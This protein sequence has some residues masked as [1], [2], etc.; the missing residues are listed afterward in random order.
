M[1]KKT[2]YRHI[3]GGKHCAAD[4]AAVRQ[5]VHLQKEMIEAMKKGVVSS[6]KDIFCRVLLNRRTHSSY[7]NREAILYLIL[8]AIFSHILVLSTH[9]IYLYGK[10]WGNSGFSN[11]QIL[12]KSRKILPLIGMA[13][14]VTLGVWLILQITNGVWH[15]YFGKVSIRINILIEKLHV[16]VRICKGLRRVWGLV[17][18]LLYGT[19]AIWS[20]IKYIP[21]TPVTKLEGNPFVSPW[22]EDN[23]LV[24]HA[25][26]GTTEG[27]VYVNSLEAFEWNYQIGHRVF[28]G[29]LCITSDGMVVLEH[30]W[31]HYCAKL[32]IEYDGRIPTHEEFMR[33]RFY[34]TNTPMDIVDLMELM[35]EHEDMY[36]MT[37]YKNAS[38]GVV[39]LGFQQIVQTAKEMGCE[40]VLGR[41]II[42]NY[43]KEF[44]HWVDS[45]YPFQNWVY[46][47][48]MLP[49]PQRSPEE[50][51]RYCEDE[52][53]PIITM[54]VDW[55]DED[56]LS[57]TAPRN[58]R[59]FVHTENNVDTANQL[60]QQ[61]AA[62]IYTDFLR[63]EQ[64]G[65]LRR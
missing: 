19:A 22:Y 61:G 29:D 43:H 41:F 30:D 64:I 40:D 46:T 21:H 3:F 7:S 24:A 14:L 12:F 58:M 37:D 65:I 59:I 47:L 53:I 35:I 63:N 52:N 60:I 38:K 6:A 11:Y 27:Y 44:K 39:M 18:M 55:I 23:I 45:I 26:G 33:S 5:Q 2:W 13:L 28:E 31:E 32:G 20:F 50:I 54:W 57:L 34:G 42:Q 56:W 17:F 25:G 8:T 4:R 48:Y 10:V 49:E 36:F 1:R 9:S 15:K 16:D 62:G 51:I